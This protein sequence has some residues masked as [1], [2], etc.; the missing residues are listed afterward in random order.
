MNKIDY[1]IR[2]ETKADYRAVENL[3]REA[4]WN[5]SVPGANEHYLVHIM[6]NHADFIPELDFVIE[7]NGKVIANI[8]YT[9]AQLT[10]GYGKVKE[11]LS[12]EPIS[13]LPEYQR[14]GYGKILI[15][16]SFKK[17]V[18]LGYDTV[19]IFGNPD[20]YVSRGFRS[21]VKYNICLDGDF[22]PAALLVKELRD[23]VLDGRKW[24]FHESTVMELLGDDEKTEQFDA[25]F[26]P[27]I[28]EWKPSQEEFFIHS[29]SVIQS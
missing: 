15:E 4:F 12:F 8:M 27:K 24:Y 10:D 3:T 6:R 18:E 25:K 17:A 7:V 14:M 16:H 20:N 23:G 5:L 22:F 11:I 13:V 21:C 19:V 9:K 28:K 26:P 1:I 2:Q 29:H